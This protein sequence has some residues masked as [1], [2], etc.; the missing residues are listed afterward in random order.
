M[1]P[2]RY[3]TVGEISSISQVLTLLVIRCWYTRR[4]EAV[5]R[6]RFQ[7]GHRIYIRIFVKGVGVELVRVWYFYIYNMSGL[8]LV[9][10][11]SFVRQILHVYNMLF[12]VLL[13]FF[14]FVSALSPPLSSCDVC[15]HVFA[16]FVPLTHRST[17][18][19]PHP[20]ARARARAGS[21]PKTSSSIRSA[22]TSEKKPTPT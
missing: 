19:P 7:D 15:I 5:L 16:P 11:D 13:F 8:Y 1:Y 12:L 17:P 9:C 3:S 20:R 4:K 18:P 6:S 10:L 22:T 21:R 14:F 2:G